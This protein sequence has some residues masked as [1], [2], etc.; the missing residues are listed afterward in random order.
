[1]LAQLARGADA[2]APG[3]LRQLVR[4]AEAALVSAPEPV[5]T[6]YRV[7]AS[8][9]QLESGAAVAGLI[10]WHNMPVTIAMFG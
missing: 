8:G 6:E 9:S 10:R 3:I 7:I 2:A 4:A 5:L 1:M